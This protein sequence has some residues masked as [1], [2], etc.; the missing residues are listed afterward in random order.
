MKPFWGISLAVFLL[1]SSCQWHNKNDVARIVYKWQD[2]KIK[3]PAGILSYKTM[4]RD[5][6]C[7]DIWDKP[8]KI[9]TYVDSV[10]CTS[11]QL[12]LPKWKTLIDSCVLEKMNIGFIFVV[13]SSDYQDFERALD[14]FEFNYPVIYDHTN[15]FEKLNRFPTAPFRTFLLDKDNKVQVTGS[16]ID[17]PSLW[18]LYKKAIS[19]K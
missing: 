17:N 11:C 5:T 15:A 2:K 18:L 10:G 19:G 12:G 14:H 7:V 8:F 4:G 6:V 13:H 16:P 1:L 3:I 9:F